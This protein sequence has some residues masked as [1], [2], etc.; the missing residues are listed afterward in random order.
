MR[1]HGTCIDKVLTPVIEMKDDNSQQ[2]ED[3][4]DGS[5]EKIRIQRLPDN[6]NMEKTVGRRRTQSLTKSCSTGFGEESDSIGESDVFHSRTASNAS[7]I[8]GEHGVYLSSHS[9]DNLLQQH[10]RKCNGSNGAAGTSN[11]FNDNDYMKFMSEEQLTNSNDS[12]KYE[13]F[14]SPDVQALLKPSKP[15]VLPHTY[16]RPN[17]PPHHPTRQMSDGEIKPLNPVRFSVGSPPYDSPISFRSI[18]KSTSIASSQGSF[19]EGIVE[20]LSSPSSDSQHSKVIQLSDKSDTAV[21]TTTNNKLH[22]DSIENEKH[23]L[24]DCSSVNQPSNYND[25][26]LPFPDNSPGIIP[27][28]KLLKNHHKHSLSR[29]SGLSDSPDPFSDLS[30]SPSHAI[31]SHLL[32][33]RLTQ[34]SKSQLSPLV[35]RNQVPKPE[36]GE[37]TGNTKKFQEILETTTDPVKPRP[38]KLAKHVTRVMKITPSYTTNENLLSPPILDMG[39]TSSLDDNERLRMA[40]P[41][42]M[43]TPADKQLGCMKRSLSHG[44]TLRSRQNEEEDIGEGMDD[45]G[46]GTIVGGLMISEVKLPATRKISHNDLTMDSKV[47]R[48]LE[49]LADDY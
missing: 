19:S 34:M 25:D 23:E 12:L 28:H 35:N 24:N 37:M 49:D 31:N 27:N 3:S 41:E 18:D 2:S 13:P 45:E 10:D 6:S 33:D 36:G 32:T 20:D 14:D 40:S 42:E 38:K 16:P 11:H 47:T 22:E 9:E 21:A 17:K 4:S 44:A 30:P 1:P 26:D 43:S 29:D 5:M 48:S 15:P 7:S 46:E 39:E 8:A